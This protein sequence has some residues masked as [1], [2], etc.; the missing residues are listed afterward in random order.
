MASFKA[1][2]AGAWALTLFGL[3]L[4]ALPLYSDLF[5][6][7]EIKS[8]TSEDSFSASSSVTYRMMHVSPWTPFWGG[9]ITL[10]GGVLVGRVR[11][12]KANANDA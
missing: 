10:V 4:T 6:K 3:S 5:T 8:E 12:P 9:I 1:K 7:R 11:R 2:L